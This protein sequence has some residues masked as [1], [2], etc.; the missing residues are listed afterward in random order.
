MPGQ[1]V[2][3]IKFDIL[4]KSSLPAFFIFI[5]AF[6]FFGLEPIIKTLQF[7]FSNSFLS[8]NAL[9]FDWLVTWLLHLFHPE[10][11]GGLDNGMV[12]YIY[13]SPHG[14]KIFKLIFY[15]VYIYALFSFAIRKKNFET[16]LA[17]TSLGFLVYFIMG[18]SAH[19][20]HIYITVLLLAIL[21]T[22]KKNY[23]YDFLFVLI[24]SNINLIIFYGKVDNRVI[25]G[26]DATV[27][28]SIL[29][30][31]LFVYYFIKVQNRYPKTPIDFK[32]IHRIIRKNVKLS[33]S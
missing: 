15:I 31:I 21:A 29:N 33:S 24:S 19:E 18:V 8:A 20:N 9:N 6:Y 30:V 10:K 13:L 5:A 2:K 3:S 32:K 22:E 1:F 11:Y 4:L 23:Y 7:S 12:R 28:F 26:L 16:L 14:I 17:Y 25:S 27:L